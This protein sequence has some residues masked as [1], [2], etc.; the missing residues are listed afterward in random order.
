MAATIS[1]NFTTPEEVFSSTP[2]A[3]KSV[4]AKV[5]NEVLGGGVVGG[6]YVQRNGQT[7][8][9][10][11]LT[12]FSAA[13]SISQPYAA[14]HKDYVDKHAFT[15]KYVYTVGTTIP[16]NSTEISGFDDYGARLIFFPP[17]DSTSINVIQRYVDVYRNGVLQVF[18]QD[19]E[20][21]NL[22]LDESQQ[23]IFP[24]KVIFYSPLLSGTV[25]QMNIGNVGATP[26]VLGVASL[27]AN[28][29]SGLR[30][31]NFFNTV[32]PTGDL[33][34]SAYP[35]DFAASIEEMRAPSRSD[36]MV[37][38]TNLSAFPLLPKAFGHFRREGGY[39]RDSI[40]QKYGSATGKFNLVRGYNV[41]N[42]FSGFLGEET[43]N[44]FTCTLC[45]NLFNERLG[46]GDYSPKLEISLPNESSVDDTAIA[47]VYNNTKTLT[48][49]KFTTSTLFFE[50]PINI[51]EI[52]ITIY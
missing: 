30:I 42:L 22:E 49:F 46:E 27:S 11:F 52:N 32:I 15:R 51:D 4:S 35:L 50:P 47:M 38:P 6:G 19:Y 1:I 8:M 7:P 39:N 36:L 16:V 48:G 37:S 13:P 5:L 26:A 33:S 40:E 29:G 24:P 9:T 25:V 28:E 12:L 21:S 41:G 20:L 44:T 45:P 2:P 14:V 43:P 3:K 17:N 31:G 34:I 23:P 10:S 18:S